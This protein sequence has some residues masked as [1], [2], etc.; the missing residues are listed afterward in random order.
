VPQKL[1]TSCSPQVAANLQS[2]MVSVVENGTARK[3]QIDGYR[4]GGKTGTAE[5]AA[6]AKDHGWFI[7]FA[8]KDDKPI[9]AV[10][11]LL[12]NAGS[13]GSAEAAR[14]GGLVMKAVITDRGGK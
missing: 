12:A 7:G 5:N 4:V 13:G 11:V 6:N 14:I 2:M 10:A 8:M 3:A 1:R 9:V